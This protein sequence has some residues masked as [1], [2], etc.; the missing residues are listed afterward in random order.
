MIAY[1]K[2]WTHSILS[3]LCLK[4]APFKCPIFIKQVVLSCCLSDIRVQLESES[5]SIGPRTDI[6]IKR[7][8]CFVEPGITM[9]DEP[10][11]A[12]PLFWL[13]LCLSLDA[14]H[15]IAAL[16]RSFERLPLC[17]SARWANLWIYPCIHLQALICL[18]WFSCI[19]YIRPYLTLQIDN[20][21]RLLIS[22][23]LSQLIS[24]VLS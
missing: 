5:R 23:V 7:R 18:T 11:A 10:V 13:Y 19:L 9:H 1:E 14:N 2:C 15:P 3:L 24:I 12:F 17:I 8:L 21:I 22:I 4:S 6:Y 16:D 20:V